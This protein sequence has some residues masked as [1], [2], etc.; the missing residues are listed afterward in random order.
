MCKVSALFPSQA[1]SKLAECIYA[2]KRLM[3]MY[4][5]RLFCVRLFA[6]H[7]LGLLTV[8]V[9][10][11]FCLTQLVNL[12]CR[13]SRVNS[14]LSQIVYARIG[15]MAVSAQGRKAQTVQISMQAVLNAGICLTVRHAGM[16]EKFDPAH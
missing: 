8:D 12:H 6:L 5:D 14:H 11:P 2:S 1:C 16:L 7:L 13:Y 10:Q 4:L 15:G 3:P 9:V